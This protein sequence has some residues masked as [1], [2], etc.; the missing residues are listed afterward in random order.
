MCPQMAEKFSSL[1]QNFAYITQCVPTSKKLPHPLATFLDS[2]LML[3]LLLVAINHYV[4]LIRITKDFLCHHQPSIIYSRHN[5]MCC[6]NI[7][8][9]KAQKYEL[10]ASHT[11]RYTLGEKTNN[12]LSL[13]THISIDN[14][15]AFNAALFPGIQLFS[16]LQQEI[17]SDYPKAPPCPYCVL[18]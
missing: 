13:Q 2:T 1:G 10:A 14:M 9:C 15:K 17:F 4:H 16:M 5:T 8:P 6:F 12:M 7:F 18:P 3:V 11:H